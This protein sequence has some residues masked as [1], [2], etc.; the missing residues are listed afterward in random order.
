MEY[1][2]D[3]FDD[4]SLMIYNAKTLI[5]LL[6][7][8][9]IGDI[10]YSHQGLSYGGLIMSHDIKFET[11][12]AVFKAILNYLSDNSISELKLKLLPRI[13]HTLP[14]DE[15]EYLLFKTKAEL[16]RRDVSMVIDLSQKPK[17]SSNR[18]RNLKKAKSN[19][20]Q[21]KEVSE[22]DTFFNAILIPNLNEK[23][24]A[25]PTHT[26][27]EITLLKAKFPNQIRQFNAYHNANIIAG[28]T[29]F[30][31]QYV[32]HAQY[33]STTSSKND[34]CGLDAIF[35]RLINTEFKTKR[36]FSFGI[37]NENQ[38]QQ[39]NKGLLNW[40]ES[41]GTHTIS[42]DFYSIPTKNY[43]LLDDVML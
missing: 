35:D 31:T 36:Y 25:L 19:A 15:M 8:N 39:I 11:V 33:I 14:S 24:Q 22:F 30:E 7:A 10:V 40:K 27:E 43:K 28:V 17:L 13:Y 37:S 26:V 23:H 2:Q 20:I 32:A 34:L 38:G 12:T 29:V 5:A 6:P 16:F 3:R 21:V 18:K 1:H 42:H 41:F 9:T 4:F